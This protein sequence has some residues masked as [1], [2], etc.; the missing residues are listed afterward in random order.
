[1]PIPQEDGTTLLRRWSDRLQ[2]RELVAVSLN[3]R[4][5][6]KISWYC[7]NARA[8]PQLFQCVPE[9][10]GTPD[11]AGEARVIGTSISKCGYGLRNLAE[12]AGSRVRF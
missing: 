8:C 2:I 4:S 1:M 11:S 3:V 9:G 5:V 7:S 12:C 6:R 10:S